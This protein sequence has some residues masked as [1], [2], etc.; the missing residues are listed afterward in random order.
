MSLPFNI[1]T[2]K[3]ITLLIITPA[4]ASVSTG[5]SMRKE[6]SRSDAVKDSLHDLLFK[7]FHGDAANSDIASFAKLFS[8]M[9]G[10]F[11]ALIDKG[12]IT[13]SPRYY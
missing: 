6:Y 1:S 11:A 8:T 5:N 3:I 9:A 4:Y 12:Y 13:V 7:A 2:K 10:P